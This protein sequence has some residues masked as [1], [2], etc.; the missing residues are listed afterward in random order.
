ML[1]QLNNNPL[2]I[3][4]RILVLALAVVLT[5]LGAGLIFLTAS[6]PVQA[7]C[8]SLQGP[9]VTAA[10]KALEAGDVK[11]V[12]PY[13]HPEAEAE[14]TAAFEQALAVRKLGGQAQEVADRFFFETTVR[15]HREGEGA[16]Y[17]GL[18][19]EP[20]DP[21]IAAADQALESGSLDELST[22]LN[23]AVKEGVAHQFQAVQ[24]ARELAAKEGTVEANR[25]RVEAELIFEK[26]IYGLHQAALGLTLPAEGGH[27]HGE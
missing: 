4:R 12:L 5:V 11:L 24:A 13:V 15:L 17:T 16:A 2:K 7:H 8:D 22:M 25:E 19:D 10:K 3:K 9:V 18:K 1:R 20:V 23:Q 21:A 27:G 6:T 26:Y 14:L